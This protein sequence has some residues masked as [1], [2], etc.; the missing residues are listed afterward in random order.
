MSIIFPHCGL[1]WSESNS[2]KWWVPSKLTGAFSGSVPIHQSH[3]PHAIS[4]GWTQDSAVRSPQITTS[5][6]KIETHKYKR[7]KGIINHELHCHTC[8]PSTAVLVQ[9]DRTA[10]PTKFLHTS[11]SAQTNDIFHEA[12]LIIFASLH[13]CNVFFAS[14]NVCVLLAVNFYALYAA[15]WGYVKLS[16]LA[17]HTFFEPNKHNAMITYSNVHDLN[18]NI[19]PT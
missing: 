13:S 3:N 9:L 12:M 2:L 16:L 10:S 1:L 11:L 18:L 4:R 15:F 17:I 7:G 6:I 8:F 19:N 5:D 14:K